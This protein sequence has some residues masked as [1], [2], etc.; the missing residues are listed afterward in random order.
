MSWSG[1]FRPRPRFPL[2]LFFFFLRIS[3][4]FLGLILKR[5]ATL[6]Q[7][8]IKLG[9]QHSPSLRLK[10]PYTI[11]L[12]FL[13]PFSNMNL[14]VHRIPSRLCTNL[15]FDVVL[16]FNFH[17]EFYSP[18]TTSILETCLHAIGVSAVSIDVIYFSIHTSCRKPEN[19][20]PATLFV[21]LPLRHCFPSHVVVQDELLIEWFP[22][23]H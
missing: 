4:A 11:R 18:D 16:V 14:Y 8:E 10:L 20:N 19:A 15:L 9:I 13:W 7:L 3:S 22:L 6:L 1:L 17:F 5:A 21:S 23:T 2:H 12:E